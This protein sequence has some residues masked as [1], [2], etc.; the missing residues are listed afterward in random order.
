MFTLY[1]M[2]TKSKPTIFLAT[3]LKIVHKFPPN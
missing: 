2:S 3:T 1:I